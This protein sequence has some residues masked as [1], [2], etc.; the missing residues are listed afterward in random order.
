MRIIISLSLVFLG[1]IIGCG[2][3]VK[4]LVHAGEY[5]RVAV[6]QTCF[7]SK[8][9]MKAMESASAENDGKELVSLEDAHGVAGLHFNNR[10][11]IVEVSEHIYAKVRTDLG[12]EC[13]IYD[14]DWAL[15]PETSDD[16]PPTPLSLR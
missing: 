12:Q 7:D 5:A 16:M 15:V 3:K 8:G 13:W 14:G 11:K 10:V 9:A 4:V 6:K 2:P 1:F